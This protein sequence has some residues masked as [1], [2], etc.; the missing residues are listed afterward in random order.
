[1]RTAI[2]Q[3][4]YLPYAGVFELVRLADVFVLYDDVQFVAQN[5]QCRNRIKTAQGVQWLTVPIHRDHGQLIKDVR[6]NNSK[7]W[8]RKH[9]RSIAQAYAKAPHVDLLEHELRPL[10]E[11]RWTSLCE[12]NLTTFRAICDVLGLDR[13]FLR[14]SELSL[15]GKG[16]DRVLDCCRA[17]GATSYL[18]GPAGRAYLR[19]EDFGAAGIAL[20]YLD[21]EHPTYEQLHGDFVSHLSVLDTLAHLGPD[22]AAVLEGSGSPV[23][24]TEFEETLT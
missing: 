6:V 16:N 5:W 4:F 13:T 8:G 17:V 15:T 22:T 21:F 2:L 1:M 11:R 10:L 23:L 19:E 18:S 14:S 20:E 7:P 9:W 12:L 24:A 3:P